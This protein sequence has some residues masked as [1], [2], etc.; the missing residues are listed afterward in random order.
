M[1]NPVLKEPGFSDISV[2]CPQKIY[3]ENDKKVI[4]FYHLII[5]L[6]R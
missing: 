1:A 5:K 2:S 3:D 4:F 6:Y